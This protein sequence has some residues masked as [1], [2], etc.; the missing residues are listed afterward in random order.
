MGASDGLGFFLRLEILCEV[1]LVLSI[2]Q[3][4]DGDDFPIKVKYNCDF[5]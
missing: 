3:L 2:N 4:L 1:E 5:S